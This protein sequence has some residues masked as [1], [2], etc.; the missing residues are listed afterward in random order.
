MV[1]LFLVFLGNRSL[2][3]CHGCHSRYANTWMEIPTLLRISASG[4]VRDR[5]PG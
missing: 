4:G 1:M 2:F 5:V 3:R